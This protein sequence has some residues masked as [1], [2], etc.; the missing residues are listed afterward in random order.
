MLE[1]FFLNGKKPADSD[2]IINLGLTLRREGK[3]KY[4]QKR[5]EDEKH[6][7]FLNTHTNTRASTTHVYTQTHPSIQFPVWG[8]EIEIMAGCSVVKN[9][10]CNCIRSFS[11][12]LLSWGSLSGKLNI[13]VWDLSHSAASQ[14]D[15][16][17]LSASFHIVWEKGLF[18]EMRDG[19]RWGW[20][21]VAAEGGLGGR[22]VKRVGS[23]VNPTLSLSSLLS[24]SLQASP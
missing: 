5:R 11:S 22:G 8:G 21:L 4:R 24:H 19:E 17:P 1:N 23:R 7:F 16:N 12:N 3:H 6:F 2:F 18:S 14:D 10:N 20:L 15:Q 9:F 13:C